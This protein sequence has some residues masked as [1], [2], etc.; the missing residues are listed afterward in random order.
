[1]VTYHEK[2]FN[3]TSFLVAGLSCIKIAQPCIPDDSAALL[4]AHRPG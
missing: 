4:A 1:M 3:G 2:V